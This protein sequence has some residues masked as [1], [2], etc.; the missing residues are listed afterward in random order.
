MDNSSLS[1]DL[2]PAP[3]ATIVIARMATDPSLTP[4]NLLRHNPPTVDPWAIRIDSI[5]TLTSRQHQDIRTNNLT[6]P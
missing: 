1:S 6:R 4:K 3:V 2:V 5:T